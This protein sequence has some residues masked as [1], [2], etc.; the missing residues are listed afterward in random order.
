M[1]PAPVSF[2]FN[3]FLQ[4]TRSLRTGQP[5]PPGTKGSQK[6]ADRGLFFLKICFKFRFL[7]ACFWPSARDILSE[8]L[9]CAIIIW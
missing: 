5:V 1:F 7:T 2:R 4:S 9:C 3:F 8:R 6:T